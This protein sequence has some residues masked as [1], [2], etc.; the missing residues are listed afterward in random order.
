MRTVRV[1]TDPAYEVRIGR[2][3]LVEVDRATSGYARRA[4]ITDDRVA[5]LYLAR[6]GLD[7]PSMSV[8]AGEGSK[9]MPMLERV[10]EFLAASDLDRS[11]CVIAL[12]GGVVG[13]L[14]GLAAS[15]YMRGIAVAQVPTTL[16]A[17]VDASVGGKTAVDLAAGKNLAGTFHQPAVVLADPEALSTL[18]GAEYRSGLGE[19][20]KSALIEGEPALAWIERNTAAVIRRDA[21]ALEEA[22]GRCVETKARIVAGDPTERGQRKALNLGHSFAHAIERAAGYGQVPHGIA[23][24]VGISLALRASRESGLLLDAGL[25]ERLEAL[26]AALE[27]PGDL[28]SLRSATGARFAPEQLLAGMRHDKKGAAGRPRL[29]L[30]RAVGRIE[31]DVEVDPGLLAEII[32]TG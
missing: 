21:D 23:V 5:P 3:I 30:P 17:Q 6:L 8:P 19:V 28:G 15:L 25:P 14:A 2:G 10:L 32:R 26:L 13:D 22:V 18:P 4:V 31:I 27:L 12:G 29:V 20:V 9:R 11:S 1:V 24:A 7:A 16:L